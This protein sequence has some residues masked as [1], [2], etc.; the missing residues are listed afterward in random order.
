MANPVHDKAPRGKLKGRNLKRAKYALGLSLTVLLLIS[1][2]ILP[3]PDQPAPATTS[4]PL[5]SE[6]LTP[7]PTMAPTSTS[8]PPTLLTSVTVPC[9]RG[10]GEDYALVAD[11]EAGEEAE[12]VGQSEGYW[13]V[14]TSTETICWI[15]N[16]GVIPQGD[17]AA[18]P[19]VEPPPIPTPAAPAAPTNLEAFNNACY[20]DKSYTP[21]KRVNRFHL[22]WQDMANNED[23]FRVYRDGN[24]VAELP[25]DKTEVIDE[26]VAPNDH[27]HVYYV[28]A[29]NAVGEA[30]S[31]AVGLTCQ[32]SE[33]SGGGYNP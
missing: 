24:L 4:T 16:Q 8:V 33:S 13:I 9:F 25:P 11:L 23:G 19:D 1:C 22:Y 20:T 30:K 2:E 31:E 29:Y 26:I 6:T 27:V 14:R 5:P 28:V 3:S 21:N 17:F 12:I 15:P 10:P 7:V 32:G 18:V